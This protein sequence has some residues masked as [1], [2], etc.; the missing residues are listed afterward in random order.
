MGGF[1][2]FPV[3]GYPTEVALKKVFLAPGAPKI[4]LFVAIG[5]KMTQNA[6]VLIPLLDR[7]GIPLINA[8][9]L[10]SQTEDQW[11]KSSVGLD[12]LERGWQVAGPEM[13]GIVQPMVVASKEKI[14]DKE[15]GLDYTEYRPI[16]ERVESLTARVKAWINLQDKPN[17]DKKVALIYYN[18]PPGKQN[19]GAAYLNVLPQSLYEMTN[20]MDGEGIRSRRAGFRPGKSRSRQREAVQ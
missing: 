9:A 8:I 1:N 17:R 7:L 3:F 5:A 18:Y 10:S 12:I 11:R 20:R 6:E 14:V 16:A 2:V 19:I 4:R 15:T 13:V